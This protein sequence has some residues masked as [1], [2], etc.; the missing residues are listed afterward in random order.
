M[1]VSVPQQCAGVDE[2]LA[3]VRP[4][5]G[6]IPLCC[7]L[8]QHADGPPQV[9]DVA[10]AVAFLD[11]V[12]GGLE[13][14]RQV[15]GSRVEGIGDPMT[16]QVD[17]Q[18]EILGEVV[19]LEAAVGGV[20]GVC[21][22]LTP[23]RG[24]CSVC[25]LE[26]EIDRP[27][28]VVTAAEGD[29]AVDQDVRE[30][31]Q[32]FVAIAGVGVAGSQV[33]L[34]QVQG[35]FQVRKA[36]VPLVTVPQGRDLGPDDDAP[37]RV[38]RSDEGEDLLVQVDEPVPVLAAREGVEGSWDQIQQRDDHAVSAGGAGGQG[39]IDRVEGPAQVVK[40]S[41][42]EICG[43]PDLHQ[44]PGPFEPVGIGRRDDRKDAQDQAGGLVGV[45]ELRGMI[46]QQT[47]QA[48]RHCEAVRRAGGGCQGPPVQACCAD[49]ELGVSGSLIPLEQIIGMVAVIHTVLVVGGRYGRAAARV[50]IAML[51]PSPYPGFQRP[52]RDSI[53]AHVMADDTRSAARVARTPRPGRVAQT[54]LW[55]WVVWEW[56]VWG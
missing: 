25:C 27:V 6:E 31:G 17:G 51:T 37:F 3:V 19:G 1:V 47:C 39:V 33:T 56:V 28:D 46:R 35:A 54:A 52:R 14:R 12:S 10:C 30:A 43:A 49:Q 5:P 21:E 34:A 53:L 11:K 24:F 29:E 32:A 8:Q 23:S 40:V 45:R 18:V 16:E 15:P 7:G 42:G 9:C 26:V 44:E 2:K 20:C 41:A 50:W 36:V 38:L 13:D 48:F 55:E 22:V 4:V